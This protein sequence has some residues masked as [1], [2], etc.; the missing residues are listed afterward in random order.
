MTWN[1]AFSRLGTV[2]DELEA[3]RFCLEHVQRALDAGANPL[4]AAPI[5]VKPVHIRQSLRNAEITYLLRLFAEFEAVLRD[6]WNTARPSPRRRRTK[7]EV[8]MNRI[9]I[10][11]KIP[12]DMVEQAHRVREY[13]NNA[14][15]NA[16]GEHVMSFQECKSHLGIFLSFLPVTW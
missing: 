5:A 7:M 4:E 8:L 13:R 6:Y 1:E 11:C 2:R 15:H 16:G 3:S 9:G 14:V 10:L 12:W